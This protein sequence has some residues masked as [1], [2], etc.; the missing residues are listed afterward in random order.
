MLPSRSVTVTFKHT[1]SSGYHRWLWISISIFE[2]DGNPR[3]IA[4]VL[5]N[6]AS[7]HS[8]ITERTR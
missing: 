1:R 3:L 2:N 7:I 6:P 4:T 8:P 5:E